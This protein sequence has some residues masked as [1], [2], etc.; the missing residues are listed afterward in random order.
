MSLPPTIATLDVSLRFRK[1]PKSEG[2]SW[3]TTVAAAAPGPV[4][5]AWPNRA[6]NVPRRASPDA[7]RVNQGPTSTGTACLHSMVA[8]H[9]NQFFGTKT[10]IEQKQNEERR[11]KTK[12]KKH[13]ERKKKQNKHHLFFGQFLFF[14]FFETVENSFWLKPFWLKTFV[15]HTQRSDLLLFALHSRWF[16]CARHGPVSMSQPRRSARLALQRERAESRLVEPVSIPLDD[17]TDSL[18]S[19][20]VA[21]TCAVCGECSSGNMVHIPCCDYAAHPGCVH[22]GVCPFCS[23]DVSDAVGFV[24]VQ[25]CV[26]CGYNVELDDELNIF[27]CCSR[28]QLRCMAPRLSA[29]GE[30]VSCPD[31]PLGFIVCV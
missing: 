12:A 19:V 10:E 7:K 18:A 28:R 1:Q 29:V 16:T 21:A 30:E 8:P 6:P 15:A 31:C 20:G 4:Q 26:E 3:A 24:A 25:P 5:F 11:T 13:E 2:R 9:S 27:S 14:F 22:N 17:D 23:S